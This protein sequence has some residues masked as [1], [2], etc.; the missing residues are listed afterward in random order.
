MS[1]TLLD[2]AL[3]GRHFEPTMLDPQGF[4]AAYEHGLNVRVMEL[5]LKH[6]PGYDWKVKANIPTG[7]V[8]LQ[9]PFLMRQSVHYNIR[10]EDLT[11]ELVIKAAGELLERFRLRRQ[12][13]QA[14][15]YRQAQA[16][17]RVLKIGDFVPA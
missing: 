1:I 10:L 3:I 8:H 13:A 17:R 14:D 6:Y 7:F 5:L 16:N 12:R 9:L 4:H 2:Q 11:D 15:A